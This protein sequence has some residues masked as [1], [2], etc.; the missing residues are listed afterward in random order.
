MSEPMAS[1]VLEADP[2]FDAYLDA[3]EGAL[4]LPAAERAD[5]R[6]EIAAHLR[7]ERAAS[8]AA[9]ATGATAT[10][11]AIDRLGDP[12]RLGRELTSARRSRSALLA[13]AGAGTW[14][15]GGAAVRGL[16]LGVALVTAV[17]V[18][19]GVATAVAYRAGLI[20][21][22]SL[23]D[24]GWFTA[25][26]G[27][28]LWAAAWQGA[29]SFVSVVANRSHR[30]AERV[31][32]FVAFAVGA[33]VVWLSLVWLQAPQNL[34]SVSVLTLV[35]VVFVAA[36]LTASDRVITR[37]RL[38]RRA[39]LALF[40]TVVLAVPLLLIFAGASVQQELSAVGRGPFDSMEE[41]LADQGFD[42]P[43]RYVAD[44]PSFGNLESSIDH[45]V[46][47]V[48]IGN[49][50]AVTA[51]WHDLRVE[52]WRSELGTGALDRA[53]PAPFAT[54]PLTSAGGSLAGSVRVDRTRDVSGYWL[55]VTGLAAD[56]QRDLVVS[57]GGT[58]TTFTG[59]ALD[60]LAAP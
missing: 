34:A 41:L 14:A 19:I 3:I 49:G 6:D 54:A 40:V 1:R 35:P 24:Q 23:A 45:G 39:S 17:M 12:K 46:A 37:S 48:E 4:D 26:W 22:W 47:R 52:A 55:A 36:A 33:V 53:H 28:A 2:A 42:M 25:I 5:V 21:T 7:D 8:G 30:P 50:A 18:V 31:R 9:G 59:S 27:V 56:G 38:A 43:G 32:P 58:N 44:P 15:A 57:V 16:V 11:E 20:G 29:R 10:A 13:A 51:R 60:W